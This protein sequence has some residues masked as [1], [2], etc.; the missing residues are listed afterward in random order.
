[1][2]YLEMSTEELSR[3]EAQASAS[4]DTERAAMLDALAQLV[5]RCESLEEEIAKLEDSADT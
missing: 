4:G 2:D 1:M 3:L 5:A